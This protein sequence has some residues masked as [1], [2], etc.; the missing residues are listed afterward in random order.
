MENIDNDEVLSIISGINNP[1][2]T[3]SGANGHW[4][5]VFTTNSLYFVKT[6]SS[7]WYQGNP[8]VVFGAVGGLVGGL[9][10]HAIS[11]GKNKEDV[12]SLASILS[13]SKKHYKF[14][15]SELN[16]ITVEKNW[17]KPV[18]TFKGEKGQELEIYISKNQYNEFVSQVKSLYNYNFS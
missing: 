17:L 18:I 15:T 14:L 5:I 4:L 8:G 9:I 13:Q 7:S 1:S 11:K 12:L 10:K 16:E 2:I 6:N 3:F